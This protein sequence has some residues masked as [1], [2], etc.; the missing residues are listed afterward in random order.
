MAEQLAPGEGIT[1][2]DM[3]AVAAV[4]TSQAGILTRAAVVNAQ[5]V[6]GFLQLFDVATAGAVTLGTTVP[7]WEFGFA[8][9]VSV[10]VPLPI[11][12]LKFR[13]GLQ[14]ASTTGEK[15][16]AASAAGVQG[17]FGLY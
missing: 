11:G 17:F 10:D 1:L 14:A 16:A 12:G 13:N 4:K 8:A 7:N 6:A 9:S 15:G 2:R 5:A 3:G